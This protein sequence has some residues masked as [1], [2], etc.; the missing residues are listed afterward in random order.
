MKQGAKN[1]IELYFVNQSTHSFQVCSW[2][3]TNMAMVE[4]GFEDGR[5]FPVILLEG[6]ERFQGQK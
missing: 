5:Q 4:A 6:L 2:S 3:Y 1:V